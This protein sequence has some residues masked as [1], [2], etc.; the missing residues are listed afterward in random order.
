MVFASSV[1]VAGVLLVFSYLIVPA[2][3]GLV[4]GGTVARRLAVGWTSGAMVSLLGVVASAAL[5]LP[6]GATVACVFGL[7]IL[8]WSALARLSGHDRTVMARTELG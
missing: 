4:R 3:A 7:A 8:P 5:D 6:T 2:L 1:R